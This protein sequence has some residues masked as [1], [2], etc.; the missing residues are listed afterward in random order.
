MKILI[1]L[2][3]LFPLSASSSVDLPY[4][5]SDEMYANSDFI[6]IVKITKGAATKQGFELVGELVSTVKGSISETIRFEHR[7]F[8]DG[9]RY[10]DSP[11]R[12][13][14]T[15]FI[16]LSTTGKKVLTLNQHYSVIEVQ[17]IPVKRRVYDDILSYFNLDKSDL[18]RIE[19][20]YWYPTQC[21]NI[22]D[23]MCS[24]VRALLTTAFNKSQQLKAKTK[25]N[26]N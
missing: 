10:T 16:F 25:N 20:N 13:G 8:K 2:V 18:H 14:G 12:L 3:L 1:L 7:L 9:H 15:Y 21:K 23:N 5:S 22:G 19:A 4:I 6:G 24:L 17:S 11:D 26:L